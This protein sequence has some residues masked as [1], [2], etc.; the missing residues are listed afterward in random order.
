MDKKVLSANEFMAAVRENVKLDRRVLNMRNKGMGRY[1]MVFINFYN[2][3]EDIA[4][5]NLG[6]GAEAENNRLMVMVTG[7]DPKNP[8]APAP[9][10]KVKVETSVNAL[11]R[12]YS[13]RGKT[14]DP[15]AVA[16]YIGAHISKIVVEVQPNF[17]HTVVKSAADIAESVVERFT[18]SR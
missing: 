6:G 18:S 16:K 1:D 14:G 4:G 9:T 3:P 15:A 12:K 13:L 10:G 5:H 2:L 17:T 11:D 8:D 7:F